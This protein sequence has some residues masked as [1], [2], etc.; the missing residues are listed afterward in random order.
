MNRT[1]KCTPIFVLSIFFVGCG[2]QP[3]K[4]SP[5]Y[6]LYRN[7]PYSQSLRIHFATFDAKEAGN[8]NM[9]NC[10]LSADL[11]NK[12]TYRQMNGKPTARYWCELGELEK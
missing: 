7:S 5:T 10:F 12:E 1:I 4:Y 3:A 9:G 11:F 6:T 8:Y 2:E